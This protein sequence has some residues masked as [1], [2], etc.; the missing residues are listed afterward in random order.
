M[1]IA[2]SL[3]DRADWSGVSGSP[4]SGH[5]SPVC[6][7]GL[8]AASPRRLGLREHGPTRNRRPGLRSPSLRSSTRTSDPK[9]GSDFGGSSVLIE[10]GASPP[11]ASE[12]RELPGPAA[13]PGSVLCLLY[14]ERSNEAGLPAPGA[15]VGGG[16]TARGMDSGRKRQGGRASPGRRPPGAS[17]G[18]AA[19]A[20]VRQG[21]RGRTVSQ[22]G[23]GRRWGWSGAACETARSQGRRH[24]GG[25]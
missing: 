10:H 15:R 21:R 18:D 13:A 14:H 5:P 17:L 25:S 2:P 12:S 23:R 1:R 24:Q 4:G 3:H 9:S 8:Q 16:A 22:G 7:E 6:R 20:Q 11:G 19:A